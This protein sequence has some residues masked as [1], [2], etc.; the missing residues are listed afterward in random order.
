MN[1]TKYTVVT[2]D[3]FGKFEDRVNQLLGDGWQLQGG[4]S[5]AA[6]PDSDGSLV[7]VQWSQALILPAGAS[8]LEMV[9]EMALPLPADLESIGR[10]VELPGAEPAAGKGPKRGTPIAKDTLS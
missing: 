2:S 10:Q 3:D 9:E 7:H 6:L 1:L 5:T 8:A 4:V